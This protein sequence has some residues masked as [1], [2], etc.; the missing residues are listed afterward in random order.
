MQRISDY[1]VFVVV[2]VDL[3]TLLTGWRQRLLV[4]LSV[5]GLIGLL[6]A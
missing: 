3:H 6:A 4:L 1:P 2:G 5:V